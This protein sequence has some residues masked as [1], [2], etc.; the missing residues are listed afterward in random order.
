MS[1]KMNGMVGTLGKDSNDVTCSVLAA[2]SLDGD[3]T[4]AGFSE[5]ELAAESLLKDNIDAMV[6]PGAYPHISKFI[7]NEQFAVLDVFTYIIPPLVFASKYTVTK[8]KYE[9]LYNH[10]A[11]NPLLKDICNTK[12][13]EQQNVSSNTVACLKVLE[14]DHVSCAITNAMC[15]ERYGLSI[16]QVIRAGIKMPFVIFKKKTNGGYNYEN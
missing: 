7:M 12:W 2:R 8:D 1:M 4:I 10:P 15:A 11:T 6:V 13:C 14:S 9:I 3:F 16:H 5:F